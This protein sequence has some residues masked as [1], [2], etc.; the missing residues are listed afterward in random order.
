MWHIL[1]TYIWD[2]K[3]IG[4]MM[5]I[6]SLPS[7]W[8]TGLQGMDQVYA[9]SRRFLSESLTNHHHAW[10]FPFHT[11]MNHKLYLILFITQN[12][13]HYSVRD[14][15]ITIAFQRCTWSTS[16]MAK[17]I[18]TV[19]NRYFGQNSNELVVS[20]FSEKQKP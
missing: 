20:C 8:L 10:K 19:N 9:H 1:E 14:G 7:F 4:C 18:E 17:L 2:P 13:T 11:K 5:K 3:Y 12:L 6:I 15:C 16:V